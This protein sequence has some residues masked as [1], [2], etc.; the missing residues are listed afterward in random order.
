M[1]GQRL[2]SQVKKCLKKGISSAASSTTTWSYVVVLHQTACSASRAPVQ[3]LAQQF[4]ASA[5]ASAAIIG[6][7]VVAT[8]LAVLW[9]TESLH[10]EQC[11]RCEAREL[12]SSRSDGLPPLEQPS[13]RQPDRAPILLAAYWRIRRHAE[14]ILGCW[15][16]EK[17]SESGFG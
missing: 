14:W 10:F 3:P 16:T 8:T 11:A 12:R 2:I 17:Q 1:F 5:D 13:C 4:S 6:G 9:R 15:G 7:L